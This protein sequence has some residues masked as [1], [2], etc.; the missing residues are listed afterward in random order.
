MLLCDQKVRKFATF[1]PGVQERFFCIPNS[2]ML[3]YFV[4]PQRVKLSYVQSPNPGRKVVGK[5]PNGI[6]KNCILQ[7]LDT[8]MARL[9][10]P[11]G[12]PFGQIS[13]KFIPLP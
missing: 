11:L 13:K 10:S 7:P 6:T 12:A 8:D 3:C 9:V 2:D 5:G 4:A 1:F